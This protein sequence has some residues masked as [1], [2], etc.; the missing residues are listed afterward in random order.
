[1]FVKKLS[2]MLY[3]SYTISVLKRIKF[4]LHT[5]PV[6]SYPWV[7]ICEHKNIGK[8]QILEERGIK[9]NK[10]HWGSFFF[11]FHILFDLKECLG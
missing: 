4:L 10:N 2:K 9:A 6:L 11:F 1:M 5:Q 3:S 8:N 7:Y